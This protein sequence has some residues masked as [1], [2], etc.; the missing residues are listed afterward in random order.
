[1]G[2]TPVGLHVY[3]TA[4]A[5]GKRVQCL[6]Q[7]KNHALVL[8]DA[9]V[10]R[11]A[12]GIINSAFGCAGE[13]CM[14]LPVVVAQ[15]KIADALAAK[16]TELAKELKIGP[17][18]DKT[19]GLGPVVDSGHRKKIEAYIESGIKDGAKLI[20]DGRNVKVPGYE[21][22]F[23]LGPTIFDYVKP[24]MKIGE[25]EIFGPVIAAMP[26][27]DIDEVIKRANESDYGLA[28]GLWTR[29]ISNAHYVASK[30]RAGTVWVNC[31]NAFDAASPFGGY[32]QS[33]MGREMG[34]YALNNYTEVKSVWI[35]L[36]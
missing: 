8:N 6:T 24:G 5:H 15:E 12:A 4:A 20:L 36:S 34:S 1:M 25:E 35:N 17:A 11:T 19:S 9:P 31:Y 10:T 28:A 30:L 21:D 32:K 29:D 26:Y 27:D 3:G 13:R 22:G 2:S 33:G 18:Y 14:A 16:L 7:A 23:Y